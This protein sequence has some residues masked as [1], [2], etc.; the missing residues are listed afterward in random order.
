MLRPSLLRFLLNGLGFFALWG[1]AKEGLV[2]KIAPFVKTFDVDT[3]E[4]LLPISQFQSF[5]DFFIRRLKSEARPIA[6]GTSVAVMPAD[7]RYYFIKI[8]MELMDLLLKGKS[9]A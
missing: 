8:S 2:P 9:F 5:N 1:F 3:A 6:S 4:F 7:G